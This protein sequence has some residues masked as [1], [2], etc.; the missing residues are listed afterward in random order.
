MELKCTCNI[1]GK[2][3]DISETNKLTFFMLYLEEVNVDTLNYEIQRG[4]KKTVSAKF[5][6]Q[7]CKKMLNI[8]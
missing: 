1:C 5:L 4:F 3:I 7:K 8:E 2:N 6:C